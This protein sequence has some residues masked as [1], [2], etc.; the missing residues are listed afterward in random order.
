MLHV[1]LP[2]LLC[3]MASWL[4]FWVK[5]QIAPARVTLSIAT[6][7][8]ISQ[9]QATINQGSIFLLHC[10]VWTFEVIKYQV[11]WPTLETWRK[12]LLLKNL[13]LGEKNLFSPTTRF[14]CQGDRHLDDSVLGF[15]IWNTTR[16]CRRPGNWGALITMFKSSPS[17]ILKF[18]TSLKIRNR[19][20]VS[21][22]QIDLLLTQF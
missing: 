4:S 9:Q 18:K 20:T 12:R 8:T 14:V 1:F 7:L 15:R 19:Y 22:L 17:L 10:R 2:S 16:I 3:V 11:G 5:L 13:S 21:S 6:F